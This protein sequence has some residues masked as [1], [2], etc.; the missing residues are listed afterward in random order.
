MSAGEAIH[1]RLAEIAARELELERQEVEAL[2]AEAAKRAEER[3]IT[4]TLA[5]IADPFAARQLMARIAPRV[6]KAPDG[7]SRPQLEAIANDPLLQYC[8]FQP[9]KGGMS[10]GQRSVHLSQHRNRM[11]RA[12][13]QV[14][15]T[16]SLGAELHWQG[17]GW[18]PFRKINRKMGVSWCV[19]KDFD[20]SYHE[21]CAKIHAL[22]PPDCLHKNCTWTEGSGY[23]YREAGHAHKWIVYRDGY[24]IE[25]KSGS[26]N[27]EA[28]ESGTID[29]IFFDEPPKPGHWSAASQ[30]VSKTMGPVFVAFTVQNR[31]V[32][33]LRTIVEGD[34]KTGEQPA[35]FWDQVVIQLTPEN[36]PHRT[37]EDVAAQIAKCPRWHYRQRILG[38]WDGVTEGRRFTGFV[39]GVNTI[40][41][42]RLPSFAF[43]HF[44]LGIDYGE[45]PGKQVVHLIGVCSKTAPYTYV[46]CGEYV[47]EERTTF[48]MD[49]KGTVEMIK[50]VATA[51]GM[52]LLHLVT[53][54]RKAKGDVNSSGKAGGGTSCNQE[55][56]KHL[57]AVLKA[58][59]PGFSRLPF[60]F[61]VPDKS[62]G[63]V[64]FGETQMQH[65][66]VENRWFTVDTCSAF[67]ESMRHYTDKQE[68]DL[69]HP[70]DAA[71]YGVDDLLK[72]VT[73][74]PPLPARAHYRRA[75]D[76]ASRID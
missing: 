32:G 39:D 40:P 51:L 50:R 27:P 49:A 66:M 9:G 33:W 12:A 4:G 56:E 76:M 28:L 61:E 48:A 23:I 36:V 46:Q 43:D 38:E 75:P 26:Q 17:T 47:S 62:S 20:N 15:K 41:E 25:F 1:R 13:N 73:A 3:R 30:R 35:E 6:P 31:P 37:P 57:T 60:V 67:I 34:P 53:A 16:H 42:S 55:F 21:L 5:R 7:L 2:R 29:A 8:L 14:G 74:P 52:P 44:R 58:T 22:Q 72:G 11:C 59:I 10:P 71:R 45:G 65:A 70:I 24:R 69:K 63:S 18:H 68:E 54:I 64:D 19:L